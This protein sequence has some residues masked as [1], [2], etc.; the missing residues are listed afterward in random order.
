[1]PDAAE[2]VCIT[3]CK[4]IFHFLIVQEYYKRTATGWAGGKNLPDS[5]AYTPYFCAAVLKAW[6]A[7]CNI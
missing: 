1:M 6:K 3:R 5:A 7:D 4:N 2:S